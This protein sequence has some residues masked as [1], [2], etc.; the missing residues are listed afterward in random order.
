ML[1]P[2]RLAR[3]STHLQLVDQQHSSP[4]STRAL[5]RLLHAAAC[6]WLEESQRCM[7]QELRQLAV[8]V[9]AVPSNTTD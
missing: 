5:S 6:L 7:C 9:Q 3:L 8:S 2:L 1:L 4:Q